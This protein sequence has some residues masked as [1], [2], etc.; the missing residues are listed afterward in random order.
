M[1]Q[2]LESQQTP[3]ISPLRASY[4]VSILGILKK[5]D[6]IIT[7]LC[8]I[9]FCLQANYVRVNDVFS[10]GYVLGMFVTLVLLLRSCCLHNAFHLVLNHSLHVRAAIQVL[11]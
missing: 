10:N 7:A 11:P 1:Y 2:I 5:I 3:H 6:R 9:V 4:G 8:C